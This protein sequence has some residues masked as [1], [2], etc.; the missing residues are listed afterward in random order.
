M[1][2]VRAPAYFRADARLDWNT[3]LAGHAAIVFVGLQNVTGRHNFAGY[4]WNRRS[5]TIEANEQLGV[6]P[7]FGFEWRFGNTPPRQQP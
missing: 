2:G 1:N 6:F 5:N 7:L 4:S 3:T